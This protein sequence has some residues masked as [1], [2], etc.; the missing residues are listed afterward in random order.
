MLQFSDTLWTLFHAAP[1]SVNIL[2]I[3][4][5]TGFYANSIMWFPEHATVIFT[6]TTQ[7]NLRCK[8]SV[9]SI[10]TFDGAMAKPV[11]KLIVVQ[12]NGIYSITSM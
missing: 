5:N 1:A 12:F 10:R 8:A 7:T 6:L 2:E 3:A 9:S 4:R 11:N